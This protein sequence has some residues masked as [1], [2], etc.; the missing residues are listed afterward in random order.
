MMI[1]LGSFWPDYVHS[2]IKELS[3]SFSLEVKEA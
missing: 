1:P 2:D 3:V